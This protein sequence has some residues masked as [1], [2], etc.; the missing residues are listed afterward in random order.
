M[1]LVS[2][3]Q[4]IVRTRAAP[5]HA[6]DFEPNYFPAIEFDRPDFP[7]LFT[8][9]KAAATGRLRPW[10]CLV[11]VRQAGRRDA[12]DDGAL[13][14]PLLEITLAGT[15]GSR[16]A[17]P[18]VNRGRGRTP[19]SSAAARDAGR[20]RAGAQRRSGADRLAAG[21][22]A[23][24]RSADE[25]PGLSRSRVRARAQGRSGL[26]IAPDGRTAAG[27][28]LDL[29]RRSSGPGHA[30]GLRS[31]GVSHRAGRRFRSAGA[32]A[33]SAQD[34]RDRRASASIDISRPGLAVDS[35]AARRAPRSRLAG[36]AS[37]DR[38]AAR[39]AAGTQESFVTALDPVLDAPA[40]AL[41]GRAR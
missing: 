15:P 5:A 35:A 16:A 37:R 33:R 40:Q 3:P 21:L 28:G 39:M 22:S 38:S 6:T 36:G 7:W 14:L 1:S 31:L 10:L 23:P 9:A 20:H 25:L 30:A 4:Q 24:A 41:A 13:P 8:P 34:S 2:I 27:A 19:S 17:R 26:P 11:V 18:G 29:W 12:A 32:A